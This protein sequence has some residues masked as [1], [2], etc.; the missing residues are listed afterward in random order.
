MRS[1]G[2]TR[3]RPS[4][5]QNRAYAIE[6]E[7]VRDKRELQANS[8]GGR[9]KLVE[10]LCRSIPRQGLAG[11]LVEECGDLVQVGLGVNREAGALGE[12]LSDEAVP[13][14]VGA[15]LPG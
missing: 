12:E 15:P 14:L 2:R 10:S 5:F 11:P 3:E 8:G 13:V 4:P 7:C 9:D 6:I 1:G